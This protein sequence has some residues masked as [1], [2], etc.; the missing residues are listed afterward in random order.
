MRKVFKFPELL[1]GRDSGEIESEFVGGLLDQFGDVG[2]GR[3][4]INYRPFWGPGAGLKRFT[5]M[6]AL[7]A[8]K[9]TPFTINLNGPDPRTFGECSE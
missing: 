6:R 8:K 2:D 7:S 4:S 3:H 5:A 9:S 1:Y